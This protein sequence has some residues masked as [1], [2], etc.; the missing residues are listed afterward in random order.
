[1]TPWEDTAISDHKRNNL[2]EP[3]SKTKK[4][5]SKEE[6]PKRRRTEFIKRDD[7]RFKKK[8]DY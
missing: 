2:F 1:L 4:E 7:P 3:S 8:G 5:F 6:V